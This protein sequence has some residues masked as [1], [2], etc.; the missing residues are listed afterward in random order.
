MRILV[1]C[2]GNINRSPFAE[3]LI[4]HLRP[5]FSVLSAG[6]HTHDGRRAARRAR[7]SAIRHGID[8]EA[9]RSRQLT[10][11]M[12]DTDLILYMDGANARRLEAR[13]LMSRARC[14][15]TYAGGTRVL[16]PNYNLKTAPAIFDYLAECTYRF[17]KTVHDLAKKIE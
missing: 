12:L 4:R 10:D 8:L 16:D 3:A 15:A 14:I 1:V 5:E 17:C 13:G 7:E 11:N 9:H 6:L 2:H